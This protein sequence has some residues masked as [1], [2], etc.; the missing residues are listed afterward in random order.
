MSLSPAAAGSR[1]SAELAPRAQPQPLAAA[2]TTIVVTDEPSEPQAGHVAAFVLES[3][4]GD[5]QM[6]CQEEEIAPST[7][8]MTP[9]P[10]RQHLGVGTARTSQPC[11]GR[12]PPP[13]DRMIRS[14]PASHR[15]MRSPLPSDR[16]MLSPTSSRPPPRSS[17]A[18]GFLGYTL[19]L[20]ERGDQ[21]RELN[22]SSLRKLQQKERRARSFVKDVYKDVYQQ[23]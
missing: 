8:I 17:H 15:V 11:A 21:P 14:P 2:A 18:S 23:L 3:A 5:K 20:F 13:S 10:R 7:P 16:V 19:A 4:L 22:P 9:M 6:H 12:S 1:S